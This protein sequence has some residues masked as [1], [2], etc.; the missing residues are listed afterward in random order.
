MDFGSWWETSQLVCLSTAISLDLLLSRRDQHVVKLIHS[1]I[2]CLFLFLLPFIF[3][4]H[5]NGD[6]QVDLGLYHDCWVWRGYGDLNVCFFLHIAS[7]GEIPIYSL[8]ITLR[9]P[10][11]SLLFRNKSKL[12]PGD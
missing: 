12:L 5:W 6:G 10:C 7:L 8:Y 11:L 3:L 1:L 2:F 4:G 9:A